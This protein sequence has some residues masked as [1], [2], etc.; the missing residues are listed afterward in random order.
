MWCTT[1]IKSMCTTEI[2]PSW[3]W[4]HSF[5]KFLDSVCNLKRIFASVFMR[6]INL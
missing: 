6:N 3:P 2:N 4:W 5:H 1:L